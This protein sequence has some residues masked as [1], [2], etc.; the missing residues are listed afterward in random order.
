MTN[1]SNNH[2]NYRAFMSCLGDNLPEVWAN[3][4]EELNVEDVFVYTTNEGTVGEG[5]LQAEVADS[6]MLNK[7]NIFFLR[8]E[9]CKRNK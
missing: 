8:L 2:I 1:V 9:G 3:I 7:L 6:Y 4:K 5:V